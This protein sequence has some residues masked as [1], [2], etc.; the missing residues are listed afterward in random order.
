VVDRRQY[1][2]FARQAGTR[3]RVGTGPKELERD[4][5]AVA[6]RPPDLGVVASAQAT[7]KAEPANSGSRRAQ[8]R[9]YQRRR[10]PPLLAR[11]HDLIR[12]SAFRPASSTSDAL[13]DSP[14]M[15]GRMVRRVWNE[16]SI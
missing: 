4:D 7:F 3:E 9:R 6:V 15:V 16:R 8:A 2:C 13:P 14:D 11:S 10:E 12:T 1:G 5:D